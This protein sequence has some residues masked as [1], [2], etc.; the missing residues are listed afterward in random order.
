MEMIGHVVKGKLY[1]VYNIK[2]S[3]DMKKIESTTEDNDTSWEKI[4]DNNKVWESFNGML[5]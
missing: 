3:S 1:F 2:Y 4:L 5:N